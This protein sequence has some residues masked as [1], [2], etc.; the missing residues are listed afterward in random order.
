M[1]V[2]ARLLD[3]AFYEN[4]DYIMVYCLE[5]KELTKVNKLREPNGTRV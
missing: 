2:F 4:S 3:I 1:Y 5:I